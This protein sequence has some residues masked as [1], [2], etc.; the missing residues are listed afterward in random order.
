MPLRAGTLAS[1]GMPGGP[2]PAGTADGELLQFN[3]T[4]GEWEGGAAGT[5]AGQ[6][7]VWDAVTERWLPNDAQAYINQDWFVDS[8]TG[9]NDNDGRTALTALQTA[10]ELARRLNGRSVDPTLAT[11]TITFS[12]NAY[13]EWLQLNFNLPGPTNVIINGTMAAATFTGTIDT[14]TAFNAAGGVRASILD[15]AA[16][17]FTPWKR[18]RIRITTGAV[19]GAI[20]SY[21]SVVAATTANVS[22]FY[23][24]TP[25]ETSSLSNPA[26]GDGYVVEDW[27]TSFLGFNVQVSGRGSVSIQHIKFIGTAPASRCYFAACGN[28]VRARMFGCYFDTTTSLVLTGSCA[29]IACFAYGNAT[30]LVMGFGESQHLGCGWWSNLTSQGTIA[31]QNNLH[32]GDGLRSVALSV[33]SGGYV[34]DSGHRGFFGCINGSSFTSLGLIQ[35]GSLWDLSGANGIFWGAAGNTTTTALNVQNSAG[36]VYGVKPTATGVAPGTDVVLSAA[37]AVA[38]GAGIPAIAAAPNNA[39]VIARV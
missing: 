31:G 4:T 30:G 21:T 37:A 1:A 25:P 16:I 24:N 5:N 13:A 33:S 18:Q 36:M 28:R 10:A 14:Y 3:Q 20:A 12:G 32:D 29:L 39:Y 19:V 22:Q 9:D 15:A 27:A 34:L 11:M 6:I 8:T 35:G 2:L 17:D 23:R 7:L 26:N 38:W